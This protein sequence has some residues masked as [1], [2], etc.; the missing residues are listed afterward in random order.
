MRE[1]LKSELLGLKSLVKNAENAVFVA[2]N[3]VQ[4]AKRNLQTFE[5][6]I[7]LDKADGIKIDSKDAEIRT[8]QM[9]EATKSYRLKV[10]DAEYKFEGRKVVLAGLRTELTI[11]LALVELVKG[12][13]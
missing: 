10:I 6:E 4:L 2:Y 13:A 9:R 3:E 12:V 8:A 11:S 7:L 5:D 1:T